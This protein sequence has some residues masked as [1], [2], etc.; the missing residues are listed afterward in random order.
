[1]TVTIDESKRPDEARRRQP[2]T[3]NTKVLAIAAVFIATF[4]FIASI[5]ALGVLMTRSLDDH[6]HLEEAIAASGGS[7]SRSGSDSAAAESPT[8][9][10]PTVDVALREFAIAPSTV[11]VPAGGTI[12]VVNDGSIKHNLSVDGRASAMLAGGKSTE[13]DLTGLAPGTY[14]MRCD[15]PGHE[16]AGM[17][18]TVTVS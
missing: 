8:S 13:L 4:A 6:R 12:R 10:A 2:A 17:R 1:M 14:T 18:G 3:L 16:A 15:V 7:N 5:M 11:D 9:P